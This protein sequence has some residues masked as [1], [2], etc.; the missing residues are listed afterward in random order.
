MSGNKKISQLNNATALDGTE[1]LP[2]VQG[3]QTVQTTAQDI[4]NLGG[5][6]T[7]PNFNAVLTE[8]NSTTGKDVIF[9]STI[10]STTVMQFFHSPGGYRIEFYDSVTGELINQVG[11]DGIRL[12]ESD[13]I[14]ELFYIDRVN[15]IVT[16]KGVEISTST[17]KTKYKQTFTYSGSSL[18]LSHTCTDMYSLNWGNLALNEGVDYSFSGTTLTI[19]NTNINNGDLLY[20]TYE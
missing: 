7:T 2:I 10:S 13:K 4:A 9:I 16:Y 1:L 19:L 6:G 11:F 17:V 14:T 5:G 3:G 12:L 15:D 8:G 18:T 20:A